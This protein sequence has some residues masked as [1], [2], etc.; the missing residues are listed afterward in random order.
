MSI[1]QRIGLAGTVGMVALVALLFGGLLSG[2]SSVDSRPLPVLAGDYARSDSNIVAQLEAATRANPQEA[3]SQAL[4]GLAYAQRARDLATPADYTRAEASLRRAL[5]LEPKNILALNG[6]GTL[7]LTRHRF[8]DAL[9]W[10]RRSLAVSSSTATTY[11]VLG[12]AQLELGR[13]E[14]AFATFD[15]M[16]SLRPSLSSYA[17][18]AYARELTGDKKGARE[19]LELAL[20]AAGSPD[21]RAWS[22]LQLGKLAWSEG[23]LGQA[24]SHY[25]AALDERPGYA[26]ALDALADV[27]AYAGRPAKGRVL[28]ER[29]VS[30]SPDPHYLTG[31]AGIYE[32]LGRDELA[33]RAYARITK[34][35]E[36][37]EQHGAVIDLEAALLSSDRGLHLEESLKRARQ[38]HAARPSVEAD[39]VLAWVLYKNDRCS[40]ALV[41]SKRSLR[42]GSQDALKFFHRGMIESC[43]GNKRQAR[44]WL[45]RALAENPYFA[46]GQAETARQ[47]LA[48]LS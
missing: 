42:L 5:E 2:E 24:S 18:V 46:L 34:I 20:D 43:L 15:R 21:A 1:R 35:E 23:Q 7:A 16:V 17:R 10:A 9:V 39:D 31:L 32:E 11:G 29:A 47:E 45:K 48:R 12:D 26:A 27:E 13:Y 25:R 38:S 41:Y 22:H 6:L 3:K 40:E 36:R 33:E 44:L 8:S 4:L 28:L 37:F 30:L 14:Q 19:A